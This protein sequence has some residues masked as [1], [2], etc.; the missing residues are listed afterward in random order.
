[1]NVVQIGTCKANDDLPQYV[2]SNPVEE[3]I[4]VEP[5]S[6]HYEDIHQAYKGTPYKIE[7]CAI[8]SEDSNSEMSFFY[9]K[10]DGPKYEVSSTSKEHILKHG[11]A[12]DE[13]LIQ[14]QVKCMSINQLFEKYKLKKIDYLFIDAEGLDE[15]IIKSIDFERYEITQIYFEGLH[16]N[17]HSTVEFLHNKGFATEIGIGRNGWDCLSTKIFK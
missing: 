15:Q 6:V 1:M 3:I 8:V 12:D 14:I 9:H 2:K 5:M 11:Y 7:P 16:M 4:L 10:N 17:V 13:N